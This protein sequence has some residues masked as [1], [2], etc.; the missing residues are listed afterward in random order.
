MIGNK[1]FQ[2]YLST[3]G[4][5]KCPNVIATYLTLQQHFLDAGLDIAKFS[6]MLTFNVTNK[7][8]T[9][10][11]YI[12]SPTLNSLS[13]SDNTSGGSFTVSDDTLSEVTSEYVEDLKS[14]ECLLIAVPAISPLNQNLLYC[15]APNLDMVFEITENNDFRCVYDADLIKK[16]GI[17]E[18]TDIQKY[19]AD[20]IKS[21]LDDST[22]DL[23]N[24]I[25]Q[26]ETSLIEHFIDLGSSYHKQ[27]KR[28][29]NKVYPF[30]NSLNRNPDHMEYYFQFIFGASEYINSLTYAG[31][32][33]IL[34]YLDFTDE[35]LYY[36]FKESAISLDRVLGLAENYHSPQNKDDY[37]NKLL[38][39]GSDLDNALMDYDNIFGDT[40]FSDLKLSSRLPRSLDLLRY[41]V[42]EKT[43]APVFFRIEM[44]D[45]IFN[46]EI[47]SYS[48]YEISNHLIQ[49]K[50][51]LVKNEHQLCV[52]FESP[53]DNAQSSNNLCISDELIKY[54]LIPDFEFVKSSLF[55]ENNFPAVIGAKKADKVSQLYFEYGLPDFFSNIDTHFKQ[56]NPAINNIGTREEFLNNMSQIYDGLANVYNKAQKFKDEIAFIG[57]K[58]LDE[59]KREP[60]VV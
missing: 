24:I 56:I 46:H 51:V 32:K 54:N 18:I 31:D 49:R 5:A 42:A 19:I 25:K 34:D 29:F 1:L 33:L 17:E 35:H 39:L 15:L 50:L 40:F 36:S 21:E 37:A 13:I 6:N 30:S 43:Y 57:H 27:Y 52:D 53:T 16:Y 20:S 10:F 23:I 45:I 44:D 7:K 26:D 3:V 55:K 48:G 8:L 28:Y 4:L 38:T 12:S 59:I 60:D 47:E 2:K 22:S 14:F 9:R 11:T 58:A 41:K